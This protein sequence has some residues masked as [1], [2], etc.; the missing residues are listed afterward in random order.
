MKVNLH[1]DGRQTTY[2]IHRLVAEAYLP[3]PNNYETVDHIDGD[4][5]H[6]Y[7]NNLQWM[8]SADNIRKGNN[9]KV[10]CADTGEVFESITSAAKYYN[11]K[12]DSISK[13]IKFGWKAG[14]HHFEYF[15]GGI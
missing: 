1:K 14:E 10:K 6:N 15:K 5:S 11:V 4:K 8:N 7:T 2:R 13:S 9:V 3:N 12:P